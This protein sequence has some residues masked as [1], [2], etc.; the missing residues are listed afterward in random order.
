MT[1]KVIKILGC[2]LLTGREVDPRPAQNSAY[3]HEEEYELR[4]RGHESYCYC[5]L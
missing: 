1:K 5:W 4:H 3:V 2:Q